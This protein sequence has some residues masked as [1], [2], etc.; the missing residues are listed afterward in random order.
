MDVTGDLGKY[1][2]QI[3]T[4]S[5]GLVVNIGAEWREEKY[6]L[7]PDYIFEN[8]FEFGRQRRAYSPLT[9]SSAWVKRSPK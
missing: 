6:V 3:P 9:A 5:S 2:I 8:G 1:G 4:A 7:S